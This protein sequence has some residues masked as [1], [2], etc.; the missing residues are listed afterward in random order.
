MCLRKDVSLINKE[1]PV[2]YDKVQIDLSLW[3]FPPAPEASLNV[4]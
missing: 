3:V 2:I 1:T 4:H